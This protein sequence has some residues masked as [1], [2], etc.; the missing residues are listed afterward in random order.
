MSK[1]HSKHPPPACVED[2]DDDK[3][4]T[5]SDTQSYART[6]KK[7]H[8][9]HRDGSDSGYSSK[10]GTVEGEH[11]SGRMA[12]L[13]GSTIPIERQRQPYSSGPVVKED[14]RPE[15]PQSGAQGKSRPHRLAGDASAPDHKASHRRTERGRTPGDDHAGRGRDQEARLHHA[16]KHLVHP[17]GTSTEALKP[18][19]MSMYRESR[20]TMPYPL[21]SAPMMSPIYAAP[22]YVAPM[23]HHA[24]S[25]PYISASA[26]AMPM[27]A[28][29]GGP[30]GHGTFL[31]AQ[32]PDLFQQRQS[33]RDALYQ[34][35]RIGPACDGRE[36]HRP[37]YGGGFAGETP[38][39]TLHRPTVRQ[40]SSYSDPRYRDH[41]RQDEPQYG[42]VHRGRAQ[43]ED[44]D[45]ND[46]LTRRHS[47]RDDPVP[48][49][50]SYPTS[51]RRQSSRP[52]ARHS[53]SYSDRSEARAVVK[54]ATAE[55]S[56]RPKEPIDVKLA[57]A[58]AYQA[59]TGSIKD[60]SHPTMTRKSST[61][62]QPLTRS[63]G[64]SNYSRRESYASSKTSAKRNSIIIETSGNKRP[65]SIQMPGG[66]SVSIGAEKSKSKDSSLKLIDKAPS[67]SSVTSES[68]ASRS[69]AATS[70]V[71]S[72]R[73]H[74]VEYT[75]VRW[76]S[77]VIEDSR[78]PSSPVKI[79]SRTVRSSSRAASRS[80]A[81]SDADGRSRR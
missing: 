75:T 9:P 73:S 4:T 52:A 15:V 2:F 50:Q 10:T 28:T 63:D 35:T 21:P 24:P 47:R 68:S 20:P 71:S 48:P 55:I 61:T 29:Y 14:Q 45:I 51:T 22:P 65:V 69:R 16:R 54:A 46:D 62:S 74:G 37:T 31:G 60:D 19:R 13:K 5:I 53:M 67:T 33:D 26:P 59:L 43:I 30:Q 32:N 17:V 27:Y 58:E 41:Y 11:A 77:N 56:R 49:P 79:T 44:L 3:N 80:R 8:R 7:P 36:P 72:G 12:D 38:Y 25:Q 34:S 42:L 76:F 1:S 40:A 64:G 57:Q 78:P 39:D 23:A 70:Y 6:S 81:S 18:R 66:V